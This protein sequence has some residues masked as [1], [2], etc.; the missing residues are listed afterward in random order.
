[1]LRLILLFSLAIS[2]NLFSLAQCNGFLFTNQA[3]IDNFPASGCT[4]INGPVTIM[5]NYSGNITN[6]NGLSGIT[7]IN[8][9]LQILTTTNLIDLNGLNGLTTLSVILPLNKIQDSYPRQV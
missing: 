6:L 5:D 4:L 9:D 3:Q 2:S 1:M 8:G 7:E